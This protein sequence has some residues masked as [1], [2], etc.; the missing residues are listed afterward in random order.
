VDEHI[1]P[2]GTEGLLFF[3]NETYFE[4]IINENGDF[5]VGDFQQ[6]TNQFVI[7]SLIY[8]AC[9]LINTNPQVQAKF[10]AL[11]A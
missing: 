2:T 5:V 10:T 8:T 4:L 1:N 9:N 7:T 6:P 11:T 3:L